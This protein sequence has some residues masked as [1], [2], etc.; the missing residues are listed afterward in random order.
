[1]KEQCV[2]RQ[3]FGTIQHAARVIGDCI[4]FFQPPAPTQGAWD[5]SPG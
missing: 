1:M 2:H 4:R 3:R 5:E